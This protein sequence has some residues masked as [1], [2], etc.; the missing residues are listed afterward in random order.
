MS[1]PSSHAG[2]VLC[3]VPVGI[4]VHHPSQ[5]RIEGAALRCLRSIATSPGG[6]EGAARRGPKARQ[7]GS[8]IV[9]LGGGE[10]AA[11]RDAAA[12]REWSKTA[13][14]GGDEGAVLRG[15]AVR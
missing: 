5:D 15:G 8:R 13:N 9:T 4:A 14:Q 2:S 6:E 10:G 3:A 11:L 1:V 7:K 12:H